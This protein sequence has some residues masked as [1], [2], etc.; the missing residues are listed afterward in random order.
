MLPAQVCMFALVCSD[1]ES[2]KTTLA[3]DSVYVFPGLA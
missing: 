3:I 1:T 2:A